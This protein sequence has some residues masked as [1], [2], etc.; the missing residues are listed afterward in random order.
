M[1]SGQGY[2]KSSSL[3]EIFP[4]FILGTFLWP[5][6]SAPHDI[7]FLLG[8]FNQ[9]GCICAWL[10]SSDGSSQVPGRD[11]GA[12]VNLNT[13]PFQSNILKQVARETEKSIQRRRMTINISPGRLILVELV[14]LHNQRRKTKTQGFYAY[15]PNRFQT[16]SQS[17][18]RLHNRFPW[19][20]FHNVIKQ[21]N[22]CNHYDRV[23]LNLLRKL[24]CGLSLWVNWKWGDIQKAARH[25]HV[26]FA[27][28]LQSGSIVVNQLLHMSAQSRRGMWINKIKCPNKC[29]VR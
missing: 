2:H 12:S 24:E 7:N 20:Y 13:A 22:L 21:S 5:N 1:L 10:A 19:L 8:K 3:A 16:F 14:Q 28:M 26:S 29:C 17:F 18:P 25:E 11:E 9:D 4:G 15:L 27:A 6:P 23:K